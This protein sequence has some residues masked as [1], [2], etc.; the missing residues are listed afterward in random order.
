MKNIKSAFNLTIFFFL[1]TG[2]IYPLIMTGIAQVLFSS[3]ANG[4]FI[5]FKQEI[6]G[7]KWIG[8]SFTNPKYF[9]GRPSSTAL[10]AYN[11]AASSGS[12]F[13][14]SNPDFFDTVK[15]R[16][17]RLRAADPNHAFW[18]PVDLVTTSASGLDPDISPLDAYYQ[19]PRIAES[20]HLSPQVISSLIN[21]AIK[22][23]SLFL[24]G[25]PTVNLLQ[26]N[27]ALDKL[28]EG[29]PSHV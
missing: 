7:S 24:F 11:A 16:A 14:P 6:I 18:V 4:S 1:L 3:S 23:R 12:N 9:W 26:L 13:G 28:T 29:A 10:F 5:S 8:Q 20:R 15:K 17:A 25:E 27:I 2:F 22:Q 19:V 21:I